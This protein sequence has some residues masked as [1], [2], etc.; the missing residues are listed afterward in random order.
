MTRLEPYQPEYLAG[1]RSEAYTIELE[2]AFSEAREIMDRQILRDVK[3]DIGGDR[4]RIHNVDTRVSDVTFKHVLL[5]VW[6]AAYRY[7]GESYR[8]VI[9]ALTGRK[10]L[11]RASS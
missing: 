2:D 5:P 11:A 4:Q 3:F 6:M 7:R 8:F 10:A 9:N 1:F